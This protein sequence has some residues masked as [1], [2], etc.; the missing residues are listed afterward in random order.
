[1]S[2][3]WAQTPFEDL[4]TKLPASAN[5]VVL[6]DA[7]R[8]LDSPQAVREDWKSRYEQA[9]AAGSVTIAP[10][11]L[12]M[13]LGTQIEYETMR[14]QWIVAVADFNKPRTAA[15]VARAS[16]GVLDSFGHTP[17]VALRDNTYAIELGPQRFA[18]MSPANR[19]SVARWLRETQDRKVPALSPFLK[20][21]LTASKKSGM[22]MVFDL[23]DAIPPD[24]IRVKLTAS[25]GL[26]AK[27]VDVGAVAKVLEGIRGVVIEVAVTDNSYARLL[28]HFRNDPAVLAP[29]AKP[30]VQ[31]V[32][33]GLGAAIEDIEGWTVQ[34]GPKSI[35][36]QGTLTEAGRRR[37]FSL[38]DNPLTA[39]LSADESETNTS[40]SQ[41]TK[42]AAASQQY[43]KALSS[44]VDEVRTESAKSKTFGQN[45]LWFDKW[46]RRIDSLPV[47]NVDEELTKFSEYLSTQLRSMA[48]AMRGIGIQSGARTAQVWD[49]TSVY[50]SGYSYYA[51]VR[52]ADPERRAIRA[53]EKAKG[54][55][56]ARGIAQEIQ[57]EMAKVRK[58]LT[59]KYQ[60][61]F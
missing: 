44:V 39:L 46:A 8:L 52:D 53:E 15:E 7:Q 6:L 1:L 12:R 16:K 57:N 23:E 50:Y 9:F 29:V 41:A 24:V 51:D 42:V 56:S 59:Q 21:T 22:V 43:F 3:A 47:L 58:Y 25:T 55:T 60:V 34:S 28:I 19:Q 35:A 32:L 30:L 11:T 49:S 4:A 13:V 38:V 54:A 2:S 26:K 14:P 17:A 33:A 36:I 31:D 18:A 10:D 45:A 48:A 5:A 61:E 37:V 40:N 27:N 20:E